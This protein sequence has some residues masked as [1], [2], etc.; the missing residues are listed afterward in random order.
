MFRGE[1]SVGPCHPKLPDTRGEATRPCVKLGRG[2]GRCMSL[3]NN[4]STLK[5]NAAFIYKM[6]A[7]PSLYSGI[8]LLWETY[9]YSVVF[10]FC[11]FLFFLFWNY[12][13]SHQ[14][15]TSFFALLLSSLSPSFNFTQTRKH[16]VPIKDCNQKE[17][18]PLMNSTV[19]VKQRKK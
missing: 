16:V 13:S 6:M 3:F 4:S 5:I 10:F 11:L 17:K 18:E 2:H 8:W 19:T 14:I 7:I 1:G 12:K 15:K 9:T